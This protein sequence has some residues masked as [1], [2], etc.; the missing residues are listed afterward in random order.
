MGMTFENLSCEELCDLM[1]GIPDGE[2]E[3]DGTGNIGQAD[4]QYR[5]SEEGL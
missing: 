1:C 4:G 2:E 3:D 5:R